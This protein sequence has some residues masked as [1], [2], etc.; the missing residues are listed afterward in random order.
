MDGAWW[1]AGERPGGKPVKLAE[2]E[3]SDRKLAALESLSNALLREP[4]VVELDAAF[5]GA[6]IFGED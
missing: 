2:I 4:A 6:I 1:A 3:M 5:E